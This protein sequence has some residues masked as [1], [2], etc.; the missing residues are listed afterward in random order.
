MYNDDV[1]KIIMV[2]YD[3]LIQNVILKKVPQN[4]P[5]ITEIKEKY[6]EYLID[7]YQL[8]YPRGQSSNKEKFIMRIITKETKL[9]AD[10]SLYKIYHK[11]VDDLLFEQLT[12]YSYLSFNDAY[13]AHMEDK[14]VIDKE[15]RNRRLYIFTK[16]VRAVKPC[17]RQYANYFATEAY[18]D[19]MYA[20]GDREEISDRLKKVIDN[21]KG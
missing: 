13:A 15:E 16:A 21:E 12:K 9:W 18:K 2:A 8:D 7:E 20:S 17:F 4:C 6:L 3:F 19:I 10:A 14:I 5:N 11:F 1:I